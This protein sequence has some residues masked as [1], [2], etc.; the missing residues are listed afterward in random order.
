[1]RELTRIEIAEQGVRRYSDAEKAQMETDTRSAIAQHLIDMGVDA[2]V[3]EGYVEE[4]VNLRWFALQTGDRMIINGGYSNTQTRD[5]AER[6]RPQIP[7]E[8]RQGIPKPRYPA[9]A[10]TEET[11]AEMRAAVRG[12]F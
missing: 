6:I 3:V 5:V 7:E 12:A 1:M 4:L 8:Y 11:A 2:G 10:N 9:A